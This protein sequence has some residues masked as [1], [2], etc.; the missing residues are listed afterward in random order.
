MGFGVMGQ[1]RFDRRAVKL[2]EDRY[3]TVRAESGADELADLVSRFARL[4]YENL[5]KII[6]FGAGAAAPL[7]RRPE[8]VMV[9][10]LELGTGGTCFSLTELLRQLVLAR[11]L[12]ARPVMAHMRHGKNT[13]C[14]LVVELRGGSFLLDPG[15]LVGR[16]LPLEASGAGPWPLGEARLV[17]AGSLPGAADLPGEGGLDLYTME[18]RGPMWRYR[19]AERLPN[20]AEFERLWIQSFALPGMRS[21]VVTRRGADGGRLYLHNHKLMARGGDASG[22][23]NVRDRLA[24]TVEEVFGIDGEVVARAATLLARRRLAHGGQPGARGAGQE[25]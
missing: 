9:E 20:A 15:Y 4:P 17:A 22:N 18:S 7:P 1:E 10:H 14:A 11:G 25:R 12:G 8:T 23:Q 16:P 21:L 3:G 24:E 5:S 2:F 6:S 19:L 13:H